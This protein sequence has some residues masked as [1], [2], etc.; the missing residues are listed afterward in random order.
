MQLT[1]RISIAL[2]LAALVGCGGTVEPSVDGGTV[3]DGGPMAPAVFRVEFTTNVG[4]FVVEARREWAP[5][6][7]DRFFELVQ[8]GYYDDCRFFRVLPGFVAQFGINGDPATTAMWT[9]AMI[10]ADPVVAH[11]QRGFISYAMHG[12]D[13]GSRTS[14]LFINL[15]NNAE[16]LDPMG[17]APIAQ[18]VSGMDVVDRL[19]GEYA[20]MP[21]QQ[22]IQE[23]GNSYL[24]ASF[25]NLS[26]IMSARVIA[27]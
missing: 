12:S 1:L 18:V 4:S 24:E 23:I 25:P 2:L 13:R 22:S 14:Q 5:H 17:F 11:N 16:G 27:M 6:G 9:H 7:V 26:W 20:D 10:P 3:G 19:D 15:A 8:A 21:S